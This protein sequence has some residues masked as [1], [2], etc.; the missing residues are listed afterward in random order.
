MCTSY[1]VFPDENIEMREII[2]RI[3]SAF[4]QYPLRMG[5]I[6]P[7]HV[8]AVLTAQAPTP[9]R[10]GLQHPNRKGL[11]L[12]ARSEGAANSPLFAPMLRHRRC[13]VPANAFY[14][15]TPDKRPRLYSSAL[16]G[17]IYMAGLYT[18][19]KPLPRFVILT[20][21]ADDQVRPVHDRMPLMLQTEELRQLWLGN[22]PLAAALLALWDDVPLLEKTG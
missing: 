12:N 22:T 6:S 1:H 11:L 9:M 19:D 4:P 2:G 8:A 7:T 16:D 3:V 13:L 10:F 20:R 15:W 14:E 18:T 21:P 5:R 17:I